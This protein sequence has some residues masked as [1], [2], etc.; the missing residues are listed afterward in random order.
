MNR[1]R[2]P[3]VLLARLVSMIAGWL[4]ASTHCAAGGRTGSA[5]RARAAARSGA[6]GSGSGYAPSSR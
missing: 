4:A 1:G 3:R 2:Q 6:P 5:A